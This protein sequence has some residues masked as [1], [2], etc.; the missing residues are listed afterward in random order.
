VFGVFAEPTMV[1]AGIT[2]G[3]SAVPDAPAKGI[4]VWTAERVERV[5]IDGDGG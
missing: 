5:V 2:A 4:A 3:A 1:M